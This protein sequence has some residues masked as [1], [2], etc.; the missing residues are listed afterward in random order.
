MSCR[1]GKIFGWYSQLNSYLNEKLTL[2]IDNLLL[3]INSY[4]LTSIE[5]EWNLGL[6]RSCSLT[7]RAKLRDS[8][9]KDTFI[10]W[11]LI[12]NSIWRQNMPPT[13]NLKNYGNP[14]TK[15]N[16]IIPPCF[17]SIS[18]K[19]DFM[20]W[21]VAKSVSFLSPRVSKNQYRK[22][23]QNLSTLPTS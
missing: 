3:I 7:R 10:W 8:T 15:V 13:R 14:K 19:L 6:F 9:L 20:S 11:S 1:T 22:K 2:F 23:Q 5:I 21:R 16:K 12:A 18:P 4:S 17:N